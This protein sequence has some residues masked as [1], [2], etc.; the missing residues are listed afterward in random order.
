MYTNYAEVTGVTILAPPS[1][2]VKVESHNTD[3]IDVHGSPFYIHD[4]QYDAR[5]GALVL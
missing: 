4:C 1:S 5:P 3:A 2:G